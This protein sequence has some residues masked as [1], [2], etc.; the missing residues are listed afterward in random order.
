MADFTKHRGETIKFN[1]SF[2]DALNTGDTVSA[3]AEVIVTEKRGT[4][5]VD[6]TSQFG[7]PVVAKVGDTVDVTLFA[8]ASGEQGEGH[9]RL[10]VEVDTT[11]GETLILTPTLSV[12]AQADPT[13]P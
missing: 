1:I 7:T 2:V 5:W 11:D 10:Q 3:V 12:T 8:G 13:A 6:V 4:A 9:Y